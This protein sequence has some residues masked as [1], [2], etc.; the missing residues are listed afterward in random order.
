LTI[1]LLAEEASNRIRRSADALWEAEQNRNPIARLST[2]NPDMALNDAYEIQM[3]NVRRRVK[4]GARICGHKIGLT[5][6][7]IQKQFGITEPDYGH[8]LNDMFEFEASEISIDKYIEPRIE[9]ETAFIL[10]RRLEGPGITVADV[11]RAVEWVVPSFEII[12]SRIKDWDIGLMDTISDNGS[13]GGV[14]LGAYPRKLDSIDLRNIKT[15]TYV[16]GE[17]VVEGN[18][19]DVLGNPLSAVAW[20]ANALAKHGIAMEEGHVIL[21]GTATK[22]IPLSRNTK[23][24]AEF[25]GL[26]EVCATFV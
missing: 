3:T 7:A 4:A 10:G 21:P 13:S 17:A 6:K 20:L 5:A 19:G 22:Y 16:N 8:L 2:I 24:K 23:V 15:V 11:I 1:N 9:S 25:A 26:G 14:I 12:D 18:T